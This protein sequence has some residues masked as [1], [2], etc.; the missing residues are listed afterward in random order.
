[1]STYFCSLRAPTDCLQFLQL[2]ISKSDTDHKKL[3]SFGIEGLNSFRTSGRI[4]ALHGMKDST[5]IKRLGGHILAE[6]SLL[7]SELTCAFVYDTVILLLL[8]CCT[9][10]TWRRKSEPKKIHYSY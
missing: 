10:D 5:C 3:Y 2:T 6:G 1:M 8:L 4:V 7:A 9:M